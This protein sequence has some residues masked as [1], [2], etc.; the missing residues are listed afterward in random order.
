MTIADG[1]ARL[2]APILSVTT[3]EIWLQLPGTRRLRIWR[4]FRTPKDRGVAG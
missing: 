1:L 3:D 2:L 4:P